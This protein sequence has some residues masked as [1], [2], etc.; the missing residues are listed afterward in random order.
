MATANAT[1]PTVTSLI[2]ISDSVRGCY[3]YLTLF[4]SLIGSQLSSSRQPHVEQKPLI[5]GIAEL[6]TI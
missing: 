2:Y 5:R 6:R 3:N 1:Y 4:L